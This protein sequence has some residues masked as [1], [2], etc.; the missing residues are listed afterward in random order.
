MVCAWVDERQDAA[1][2]ERSSVG[3]RKTAAQA[4]IVGDTLNSLLLAT[5]IDF[6]TAARPAG[7]HSPQT[8]L[9]TS[10][11]SAS[12]ANCWSSV[13]RLPNKVDANPHC[14]ESAS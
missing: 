4:W 2:F 9:A 8:S 7:Y 6:C 14:G 10:T 3:C 5:C 11:T 12:F 13:S 1:V